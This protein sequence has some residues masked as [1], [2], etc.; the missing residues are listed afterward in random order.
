MTLKALTLIYWLVSSIDYAQ[1]IRKFK[2]I[3]Y[4]WMISFESKILDLHQSALY[5]EAF[6]LLILL[7]LHLAFALL[8]LDPVQVYCV[9]LFVVV[10][11]WWYFPNYLV[12]LGPW[13]SQQHSVILLLV[14]VLELV[15]GLQEGRWVISFTI[16][17]PFLHCF[18]HIFWLDQT[19]RFRMANSKCL[20]KIM[21]DRIAFNNGAFLSQKLNS[22]IK[23]F[24]RFFFLVF[25]HLI[26][27]KVQHTL[28][29]LIWV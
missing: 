15:L 23:L 1:L 22:F 16:F 13:F 21:N 17:L 27:T 18:K 19:A 9:A 12:V 28:S 10:F 14:D 20:I 29:S 7:H 24:L 2:L 4:K 8:Q 26:E 11:S 25:P 5:R 3:F 6:L